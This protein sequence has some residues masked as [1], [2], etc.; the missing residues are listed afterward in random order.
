MFRLLK[1]LFLCALAIAA[2]IAAVSVPVAGK[3]LAGHVQ[4]WLAEPPADRPAARPS[5]KSA[6]GPAKAATAPAKKAAAR[7]APTAKP[8]PIEDDPTPDE[9]KALEK[10]IGSRAA[11][12][13]GAGR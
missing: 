7:P 9:R 13:P 11:E 8:R 5:A 4:A 10:L 12:P 2:G 1:F 6:A 3:T